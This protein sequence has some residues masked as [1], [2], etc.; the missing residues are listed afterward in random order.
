[1]RDTFL[2]Y[3]ETISV[4]FTD[5]IL[6]EKSVFGEKYTIGCF[7]AHDENLRLLVVGSFAMMRVREENWK[8]LFEFFYECVC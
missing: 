1:M 4:G 6:T 5:S 2:H 3:G 8:K 7:F